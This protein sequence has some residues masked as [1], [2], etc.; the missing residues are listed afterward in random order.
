MR[1]LALIH[2]LKSQMI[3]FLHEKK[4]WSASG[5][6][7]VVKN[8]IIS[9]EWFDDVFFP[10]SI[11]NFLHVIYT[12]YQWKPILRFLALHDSESCSRGISS[13][14]ISIPLQMRT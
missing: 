14:S 2:F 1:D 12:L 6:I 11:Y 8:L 5:L 7:D 10:L 9:S 3:Y 4:K 13:N